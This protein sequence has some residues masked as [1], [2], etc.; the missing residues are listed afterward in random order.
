MTASQRLQRKQLLAKCL[1]ATCIPSVMLR[2]QFRRW[3]PFIRAV[4]YHGTPNSDRDAFESHLKFFQKHFVSVNVADLMDLHA[5]R[6]RHSKPGLIISFDDAVE[7]N[8]VVAGPLLERYG[9]VGWY[10]VP[11]C[12]LDASPQEQPDYARR[13]EIDVRVNRDANPIQAMSWDQARALQQK[14]HIIGSH[15]MHHRRLQADLTEDQLRAEIVDS[16]IELEKRISSPVEAFSWVGGRQEDYSREAA[17]MIEKAGYKASF[18]TNSSP[19]RPSCNL[20]QL[21]RTHL[22]SSWPLP[23]VRLQLSGIVDWHYRR[24]RNA[25]NELTSIAGASG[26]A[27]EK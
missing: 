11:V 16:K 13:W 14:G 20:H 19:I 5:G 23:L 15:T 3:G 4:N 9:F 25:V 10:F 1:D 26:K 27:G 8:A 6:W 17:M 24:K 2:S 12:F 22:E 7:D 18:M 21:Q